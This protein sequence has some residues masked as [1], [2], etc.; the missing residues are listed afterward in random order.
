MPTTTTR[1]KEHQKRW[2]E[3]VSDPALEDLP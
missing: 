1:A 3:I 2:Q